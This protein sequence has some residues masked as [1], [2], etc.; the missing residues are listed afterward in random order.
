MSNRNKL[1]ILS[2]AAITLISIFLFYQTGGNWDY[3]LPRRITKILAIIL[4]G[5]SI[6]VSTVI[7]QTIT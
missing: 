4:T 2:I 3:I 7:F 6:A 1:L 5:Y